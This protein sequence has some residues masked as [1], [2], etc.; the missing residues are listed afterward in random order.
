MKTIT[1]LM[2]YLIVTPLYRQDVLEQNNNFEEINRG[3]F[4]QNA[5]KMD[6]IHDPKISEHY[7]GHLQKAHDLTASDIQRGRDLGIGGYNEYRRICGLK[8]AKTFEDFSDV[9]DIEIIT[10]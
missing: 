1:T 8:A 2:N 10:P 3:T 9:I 4:Y 7:F 5:A 6:D